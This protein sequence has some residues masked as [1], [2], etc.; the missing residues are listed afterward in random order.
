MD[1]STEIAAI[2]A[3]SQ[4]SELRQPLVGALNKLNSGALPAVT[5]SDVGKILKVGANGWEL[6]EKSGYMPVPTDTKQIV[7]NGTYD[8]T[9]YASAQVYVPSSSS[10]LISKTIT[11]NG[12]YDPTDDNADGYS[13]VIVNVSA[14]RESICRNWDFSNIVNTRGQTIY[15]ITSYNKPTINGWCG[16][17]G[18][19]IEIVQGGIKLSKDSNDLNIYQQLIIDSSDFNNKD[20]V[21]SCL[22][23]GVLYTDQVNIGTATGLIKRF[24]IENSGVYVQFIRDSSTQLAFSIWCDT[25]SVPSDILIQAIKCEFGTTQT[26]A[27]Q[28][29][30]GWVLLKNQDVDM[31]QYLTRKCCAYF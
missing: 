26:L 29:G 11:Q 23:N 27:K 14:V 31:E 4:G 28:S 12:T 13:E 16:A 15:H 21:F 9:N 20:A 5:A 8:V 6:G 17:P 2:Q 18:N 3:A 22:A 30:Q 10:T 19:A 1:I 25:S 7:E 24:N